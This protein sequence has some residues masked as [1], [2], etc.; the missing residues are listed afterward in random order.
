MNE[1]CYMIKNNQICHMFFNTTIKI[2]SMSQVITFKLKEKN[3]RTWNS[4]I[5]P[6]YYY[7]SS[8]KWFT[9]TYINIK[10][11]LMQV[12]IWMIEIKVYV[13]WNLY[14]ELWVLIFFEKFNVSSWKVFFPSRIN[15]NDS[16]DVILNDMDGTFNYW[17]TS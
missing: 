16:Y 13:L 17:Y 1:R 14:N 10:W 11:L 5:N 7:N 9:Y 12:N 6:H 3:S 2:I 4:Y 8:N 15:D